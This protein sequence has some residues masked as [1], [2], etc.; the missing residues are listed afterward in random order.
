MSRSILP[1]LSVMGLAVLL[2]GIVVAPERIHVWIHGRYAAPTRIAVE[3]WIL[4]A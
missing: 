1:G 2:I 4:S 3:R